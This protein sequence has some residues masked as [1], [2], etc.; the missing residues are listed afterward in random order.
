LFLEYQYRLS[1]GSASFVL[2]LLSIPPLILGGVCS[3]FVVKKFKNKMRPC[4][5]FLVVVLFLNIIVY[6]GFLIYCDETTI[7]SNSRQS[8]VS[9]LQKCYLPAS[10]CNCKTSA[11]KPVCL[12]G[13]NDVIFK[14]PCLAGCTGYDSANKKFLGCSARINKCEPLNSTF[15]YP[16][17]TYNGIDYNEGEIRNGLCPKSSSC[18]LRLIFSCASIFLLMFMNALTFIPYLKIT[19]GCVEMKEMNAVALGMKQLVMNAFGTIP[20]PILFGTV[21]DS[22]CNYWHFD[23]LGQRVCKIYNNQ[24][25]SF[26]FGMLGIGFKATCFVLILLSLIFQKRFI[27]FEVQH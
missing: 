21:I 18:D 22:T 11:F 6:A 7:I 5:K 19:M 3:G 26:G 8:T 10:N 13:S 17:T 27:K 15:S 20:G 25:F 1:S 4:L 12:T 23:S 16:K 2:G 24:N 14:T 9:D